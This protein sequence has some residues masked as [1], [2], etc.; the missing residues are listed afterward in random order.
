MSGATISVAMAT[1]EGARYLEAQLESLCAQ[2]RLPD[3]LILCDDASSDPTPDIAEAFARRAPFAVRI[4]RNPNRLGITGNFEQAVSLCSGDLI[5]LADQDDVWQETKLENLSR[6]LVDDPAVGAVFCNGEVVDEVLAPLGHDLWQA[7]AFTPAEQARVRAGDAVA[8][9][10]K[11]VVAAGS[12]MAFRASYRELLLPFPALHSAHDAWIAFLIASVAEVRILDERLIHYRV[13][14][15]NTFGIRKLSF[16]EQLEKAREQLTLS[17]FAYAVDFFSA[18][19]ERL[20]ASEVAG[21]PM[22]SAVALELVEDKIRHARCRDE[23]SST[24]HRRLPA[25]LR[26]ALSGRYARYSYGARSFAQDVFL[27]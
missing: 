20:G 16:R 7:L 22:A 14:G 27:R 25:M 19:R 5:F 23:M 15:E 9:F 3:E 2:T 8:V 18:A 4:E 13:H 6:V 11:H 1:C 10:L 17:A 12:T 26:E 24:L 21:G